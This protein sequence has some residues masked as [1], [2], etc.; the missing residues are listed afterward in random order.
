MPYGLGVHLELA[1][2]ARGRHRERP[3]ACAWRRRAAR[4][5]SGSSGEIGTLE[6]GKLADFVVID[7]DPL[8]HIADT[9]RIVAVVKGGVWQD[10]SSLLDAAVIVRRLYVV[11]ATTA[12]RALRGA[13]KFAQ[14]CE[15]AA[16]ALGL[17]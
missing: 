12:S 4:W 9:L 1:L 15:T 3:G 13:A 5:R 11:A 14:P 17:I 10:R 7:G 8:T 16:Y 2:L 6:E